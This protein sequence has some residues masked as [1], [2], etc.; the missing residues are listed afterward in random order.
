MCA[1]MA[2]AFFKTLSER[3]IKHDVWQAQRPG[4]VFAGGGRVVF[5][6]HALSEKGGQSFGGRAGKKAGSAALSGLQTW[7]ARQGFAEGE[8]LA[9]DAQCGAA[10]EVW[11]K[12]SRPR[13][14]HKLVCPAA[15][16]NPALCFSP[17]H[18]SPFR[19]FREAFFCRFM[20]A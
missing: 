12:R 19:S 2:A 6:P 4:L 5:P 17:H 15:L 18:P 7:D 1:R 20:C 11:A 10:T 8:R 14:S 13:A 3:R 16:L 9:C